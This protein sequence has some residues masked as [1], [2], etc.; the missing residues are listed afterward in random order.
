MISGLLVERVSDHT[1]GMLTL[2]GMRVFVA[3]PRTEDRNGYRTS[4]Q[5]QMDI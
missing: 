4:Q 5:R 2:T 1:I 3:N